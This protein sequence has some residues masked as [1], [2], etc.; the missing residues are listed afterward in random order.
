MRSGRLG[1]GPWEVHGLEGETQGR[2]WGKWRGVGF[3]RRD[4][5]FLKTLRTYV[6]NHGGATP[7]RGSGKD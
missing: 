3:P 5:A 1:V 7:G 2:E 6:E 4:G